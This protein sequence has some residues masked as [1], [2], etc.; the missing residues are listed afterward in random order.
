[1]IDLK[2]GKL[3]HQDI[4]QIDTYVRYYEDKVRQE[5]DNPT[6]GLI[7]CSEKN[8]AVV[9]YSLLNDSKQIFA[10]KYMTYLPTEK[11]LQDEIERERLQIEQEKN[12][13]S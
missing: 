13:D 7:L 1:L 11:E 12:L 3:T 10:S 4:G 6:I 9:K 5:T 8:N 2:T